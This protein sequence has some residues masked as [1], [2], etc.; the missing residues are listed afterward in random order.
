MVK[1]H[2]SKYMTYRGAAMAPV[3]AAATVARVAVRILME[4]SDV[5]RKMY[6]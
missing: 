6:W 2:W 1:T 3:A 5:C 4:V